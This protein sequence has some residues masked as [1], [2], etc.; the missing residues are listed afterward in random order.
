MKA[1][2]WFQPL[3]IVLKNKSSDKIH[4]LKTITKVKRRN[5]DSTKWIDDLYG[6]IIE[7]GLIKL[8]Q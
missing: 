1:K 4:T 8:H 6:S 7:A 3:D 2:R 5:S